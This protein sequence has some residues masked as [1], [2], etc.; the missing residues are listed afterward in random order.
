MSDTIKIIL[1]GTGFRAVCLAS[2]LG[3]AYLGYR[4]YIKG[5]FEKAEEIKG[6]FGE[7]SVVLRNVAPGVVFALFGLI[8]GALGVIRPISIDAELRPTTTANNSKVQPAGGI[9]IEPKSQMQETTFGV[10]EPEPPKAVVAKLSQRAELT[11]EDEQQLLKSL[12]EMS[13]LLA[14]YKQNGQQTACNDWPL[15]G[16]THIKMSYRPKEDKKEWWEFWKP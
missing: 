15:D 1:I 2:G 4:L 10:T 9:A 7:A 5:V 16:T 14:M 6:H 11:A 12:S 3:F 13:E 8:C